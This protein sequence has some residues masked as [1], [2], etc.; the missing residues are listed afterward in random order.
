MKH[1]GAKEHAA[2]LP[3]RTSASP[4]RHQLHPSTSLQATP[5]D[6]ESGEVALTQS[7][8]VFLLFHPDMVKCNTVPLPYIGT[9][10]ST[11]QMLFKVE[12]SLQ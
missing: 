6:V 1:A 5:F 11:E 12:S 2:L 3:L 4:A 9:E 7:S 10:Y 8:W